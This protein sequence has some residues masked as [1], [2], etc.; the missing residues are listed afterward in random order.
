MYL[1]AKKRIKDGKE[2]RYWS[3]VESCRNLDGRVVQR[4][5]LYLG[6]INDSQK[7]AWWR[8]ID[9]LQVDSSAKQMAL[10]PADR[11][12][13]ELECEVVQGQAQRATAPSSASVGRVLVG[14]HAVGAVGARPI[15]A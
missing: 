9:V 11:P 6:E 13:P 14:A 7:A 3:I 2:H 15:L 1:R 4:Q 10:F 5:V 12:A 8:T